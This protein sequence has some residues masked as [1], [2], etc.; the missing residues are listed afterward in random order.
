MV[1][2][3]W[4]RTSTGIF[5]IMIVKFI[6]RYPGMKQWLKNDAEIH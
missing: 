3:F 1:N 5:K 4:V 2:K 6:N